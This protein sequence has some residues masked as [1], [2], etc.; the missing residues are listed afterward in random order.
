MER[1]LSTTLVSRDISLLLPLN[2]LQ[3]W[4]GRNLKDTPLANHFLENYDE[5][6]KQSWTYVLAL[7]VAVSTQLHYMEKNMEPDIENIE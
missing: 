3:I 6:R 4:H 5:D 7:T 2:T 1:T